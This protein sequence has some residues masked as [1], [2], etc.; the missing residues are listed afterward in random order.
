M[1]AGNDAPL[2][3]AGPDVLEAWRASVKARGG[4]VTRGPTQSPFPGV[5]AARYGG[6][7]TSTPRAKPR[8]VPAPPAVRAADAASVAAEQVP[9]VAAALVAL[10]LKAKGAG[11][12]LSRRIKKADAE[13]RQQLA[14]VTT[15]ALTLPRQVV[16]GV[17]GIP[18]WLVPVL[19]IGGAGYVGYQVLRSGGAGALASRLGR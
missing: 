7:G 18:P 16:G 12:E 10:D 17:L 4:M 13:L 8:Y 9:A 5:L 15:G 2:L 14:E 1:F 6:A 11:V 3:G 19:V